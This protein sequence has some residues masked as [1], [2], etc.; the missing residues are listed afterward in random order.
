[1]SDDENSGPVRGS[2]NF[3]ADRGYA[4]PEEASLKILLANKVAL[5]LEDQ[6]MT[7]VKAAERSGLA[8][9][10]VSRIVNGLV[11]DYSVFRLMRVLTALGQDIH[12]G[13]AEASSG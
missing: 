12:L 8:Q 1:M 9:A 3:L 13:W 6:R 4:D 11:K 7:Q 5:L 2:G 10:D